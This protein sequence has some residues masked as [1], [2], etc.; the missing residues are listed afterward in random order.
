MSIY[1]V[2][3]SGFKILF[4]FMLKACLKYNYKFGTCNVL[5][6]L[7]GLLHQEHYFNKK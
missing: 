5:I 1:N 7:F 6:Y 4:T 2:Y 3:H